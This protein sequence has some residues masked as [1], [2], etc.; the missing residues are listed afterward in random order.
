M[1]AIVLAPSRSP[2][3]RAARIRAITAQVKPVALIAVDVE[4]D[5]LRLEPG[6]TGAPVTVMFPVAVF[7]SLW[8]SPH[9]LVYE[10]ALLVAAA[11]VLWLVFSLLLGPRKLGL[12]PYLLFL[13]VAILPWWWFTKG[14]ASMVRVFQKNRA[15]LRNSV[16]PTELWVLRVLLVST[17]EFVLSLP[18]VLYELY[19]F[20]LPAFSPEH[21]QAARPL[22]L[23]V[24]VLFV[25][26]VLFGYFVVLPAALHFG[27]MD[28]IFRTGLHEYLTDFL[29]RLNEL[30]TEV[31][32][33]FFN[34]SY[35]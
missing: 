11:V 20:V 2:A 4:I 35:A 26:G 1:A 19:S 14:V 25:I 13:S 31:N 23:A 22:L 8:A 7:L 16:L 6:R 10:W 12:Q 30:G 32:R 3:A 29:S 34:I 21:Q 9:A 15:Q 5:Q 17:M 18:V 24:P 33:G 27:R 28:V